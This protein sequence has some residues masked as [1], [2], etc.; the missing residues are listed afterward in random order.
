MV[1]RN[2]EGVGNSASS[3]IEKSRPAPSVLMEANDEP[4][5]NSHYSLKSSLFRSSNKSDRI[6][7]VQATDD[8][9]QY[10]LFASGFQEYQ[11]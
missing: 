8:P 4:H 2:P 10:V 7:L 6:C 1:H 3:T 11:K 9:I 5:K